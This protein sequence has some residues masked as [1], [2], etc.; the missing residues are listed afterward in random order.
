ME[1]KTGEETEKTFIIKQLV[2]SSAASIRKT[3]K[4]TILLRIF[5]RS[6]EA[7]VFTEGANLKYIIT[8]A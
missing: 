7:E 6:I 2:I 4:G 8:E 1:R 3:K 5:L